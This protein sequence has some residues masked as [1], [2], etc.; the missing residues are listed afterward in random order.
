LAVCWWEETEVISLRVE[1]WLVE[2]V[3]AGTVVL[4]EE[5]SIH[6]VIQIVDMAPAGCSMAQS[7]IMVVMASFFLPLSRYE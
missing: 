3:I 4:D 5:Y 2:G 7:P 1:V 6:L